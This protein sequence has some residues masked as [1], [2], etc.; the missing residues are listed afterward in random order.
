MKMN[1]NLLKSG[2]VIRH[3]NKIYQIIGTNIIKPGKGGAYIQVE[4]RDLMT[5][6]KTNERWRTS[7]DVEKLTTEEVKCVYLFSGNNKVT[8][9]NHESYEQFEIDDELIKEKLILLEDGMQLTVE[10]VDGEIINIKFPKSI[11]VE[12]EYADGVVKGQTASSS[13]KNAITNKGLKILV[14]PHIKKGDKVLIKSENFEYLEK[15]KN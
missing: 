4:M 13:F 14:P 5:N 12:I 7:D 2:N 10:K 3:Q 8:L 15:S 11:E 1:A 9:M 6:L